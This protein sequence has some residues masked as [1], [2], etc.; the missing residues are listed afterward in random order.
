MWNL[1]NVDS[2]SRM[3]WWN[4]IFKTK[5]VLI[6]IALYAIQK[7]VNQSLAISFLYLADEVFDR[8]LVMKIFFK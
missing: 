5:K 4:R 8:M 2:R 6:I 1:G 3:L 7:A